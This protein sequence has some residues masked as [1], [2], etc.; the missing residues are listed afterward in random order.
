MAQDAA[1]L[2]ELVVARLEAM[3]R[4][5]E[6]NRIHIER[7]AFMDASPALQSALLRTI[8]RQLFPSV[9]HQKWNANHV[10]S[11]LSFVQRAHAGRRWSLPGKG[12]LA[13]ERD[14]LIFSATFDEEDR[15]TGRETPGPDGPR[16]VSELLPAPGRGCSFSQPDSAFLDASRVRP[17]FVLRSILPGDRM[18]PH[19]M[20]GHKKV[21]TLMSERGVPRERR[22]R[23][24]VVC[25]RER[26]VWAVGI[27]TT[28]AARVSASTR[29][30]WQLRVDATD[31]VP[32]PR[33][34]T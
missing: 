15:S 34:D 8:A 28:Q 12:R 20:D 11:V 10:S 17:P 27:T 32:S 19:G 25:D 18:Q 24:L 31:D 33:V 23:Q 26:I 6:L 1:V 14:G 2:D 5:R 7:A 9:G 4:S 22:D 29:R 16:L 13:V 21:V 30:V 3:T